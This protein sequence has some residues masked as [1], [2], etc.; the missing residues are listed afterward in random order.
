MTLRLREGTIEGG[1]SRWYSVD[2]CLGEALDLLQDRL[3][4]EE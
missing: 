2:N 1:S 3:H 4:N